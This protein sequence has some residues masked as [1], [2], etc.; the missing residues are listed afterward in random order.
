M[1][2]FMSQWI[3]K[4]TDRA[5]R[6]A[7]RQFEHKDS[8]TPF[9]EPAASYILGNTHRELE[10]VLES[11]GLT[12]EEQF[13]SVRLHC[14]EPEYDAGQ[15]QETVGIIGTFESGKGQTDIEALRPVIKQ[16]VT[17][18]AETL[19]PLI[20]ELNVFANHCGHFHN[21]YITDGIS[22]NNGYNCR[23]CKQEESREVDGKRYGACF[24]HS[25]PL[26]YPP[27]EE[28]L[29]K[30]GILSAEDVDDSDSSESSCDYIVVT[31]PEIVW[32]LRGEGIYGEALRTPS[33]LDNPYPESPE[34]AG[35]NVFVLV[36][37]QSQEEFTYQGES[38]ENEEA[39]VGIFS[40]QAKAEAEKA[41]LEKEAATNMALFQCDPITFRIEPYT[42]Q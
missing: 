32:K 39:L 5:F 17:L 7:K 18:H 14:S 1:S 40:T 34:F 29:V 19:S 3:D 11:N 22:Y 4:T 24:C 16:A 35:K 12:K 8:T 42:V 25:C 37:I 20:L 33:W 30:Y 6:S 36:A 23:H 27:A 2:Q 26:G 38:A 21:A 10:M 28:D 41:K 9:G 13:Y 31:D 15:Y